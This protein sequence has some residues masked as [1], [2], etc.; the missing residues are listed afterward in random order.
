VAA[1]TAF[2]GLPEVRRSLVAAAGGVFRLGQRVPITAAMEWALTGDPYPADV[3]LRLGLLHAVCD[4]GQALA[5]AGEL[6]RRITSNAP[7]AVRRS[8]ALLLAAGHLDDDA[9]RAASE[10]SLAAVTRTRDFH[11]PVPA[12]REKRPPEWT[13][14]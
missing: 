13:A 4:P 8:R 12:F 10:E 7:I 1:S 2:L 11:E 9:A 3:A 6:A 5:G 14:S